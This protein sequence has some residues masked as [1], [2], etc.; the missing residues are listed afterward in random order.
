MSAAWRATWPASAPTAGSLRAAEP[1]SQRDGRAAG[2]VT[3]GN[4]SPM[5][6]C[7]IAMAFLDT[8]GGRPEA[9]LAVEIEQRGRS[10]AARVVTL[11]FVQAGQWAVSQ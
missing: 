7:G 2:T 8:D 4:F 6:E 3:S 9:G 10:L 1:W 11:P 5:L